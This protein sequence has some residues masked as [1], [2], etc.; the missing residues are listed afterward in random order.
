VPARVPECAFGFGDDLMNISG[1]EIAT[2]FKMWREKDGSMWM[3]ILGDDGIA[4][5][6]ETDRLQYA[7]LKWL[8]E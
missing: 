6:M 3:V 7:M 4:Y 2:I 8:Y 5:T 1:V